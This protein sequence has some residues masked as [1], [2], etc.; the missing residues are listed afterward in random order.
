MAT[1]WR[2]K[3]LAKL[4]ICGLLVICLLLIVKTIVQHRKLTELNKK[5]KDELRQ[6]KIIYIDSLTG[7]KNRKAY[8]DTLVN[9]EKIVQKTDC[10]YAVMIDINNFKKVN[11]TFGHYKGDELLKNVAK[12]L[13]KTF[14]GYDYMIFRIGGDEFAVISINNQFAVLNKKIN[15]LNGYILNEKVNCSFSVG[16][17]LVKYSINNTIEKAFM[18]ADKMMYEEKNRKKAIKSTNT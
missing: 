12:V 8:T 17:S 10:I 3:I 2:R 11:D 14:N 6:N 15:H 4:I 18:E 13:R 9:L 5:L 16:Y 1:A 7:L